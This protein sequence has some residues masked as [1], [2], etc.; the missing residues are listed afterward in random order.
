MDVPLKH[1]PEVVVSTRKLKVP[2]S[3]GPC[4][5][6]ASTI[7]PVT[8]DT[9]H[10]LIAHSDDGEVHGVGEDDGEEDGEAEGEGLGD[11][12]GEAD[13][14]GEALGEVDG[15]GE[16]DAV[17]AGD[18]EAGCTRSARLIVKQNSVPC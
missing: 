13:P 2:L 17:G 3:C 12:L 1:E 14:D 18:G 16:A 6:G 4:R 7:W 10:Q 8:G 11:A 9:V 15:H 5:P